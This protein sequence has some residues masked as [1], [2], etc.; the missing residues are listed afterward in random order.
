MAGKR[1]RPHPGFIH[2]TL[3]NGLTISI[4][5]RC[6]TNI[7]SPTP[8]SLRMAEENHLCALP[9][10]AGKSKTAKQQAA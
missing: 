5:Q 3:A 8:A 9:H 6:S 4:C 7:G 2:T 10:C 1:E